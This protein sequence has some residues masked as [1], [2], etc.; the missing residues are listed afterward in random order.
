[1]SPHLNSTL[2]AFVEQPLFKKSALDPLL[3][4]PFI[5]GHL[6]FRLAIVSNRNNLDQYIYN[7]LLLF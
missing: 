1:M 5:S 2:L 4:A 3:E 6:Q 7:I